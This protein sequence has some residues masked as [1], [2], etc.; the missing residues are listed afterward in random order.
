MTLKTTTNVSDCKLLRFKKFADF[1]GG[2]LVMPPLSTGV[3]ENS[4]SPVTIHTQNSND[5]LPQT[6][7]VMVR[8]KSAERPVPRAPEEPVWDP[9][10]APTRL[11]RRAGSSD[12]SWARARRKYRRRLSL[13]GQRLAKYQRRF[14]LAMEIYNRKVALREQAISLNSDKTPGY[15]KLLLWPEKP[16]SGY[17]SIDSGWHYNAYDHKIFVIQNPDKRLLNFR[18]HLSGVSPNQ[19]TL[20]ESHPVLPRM[21][22][23]AKLIVHAKKQARRKFYEHLTDADANVYQMVRERA[24][25]YNL[26][27]ESFSALAKFLKGPRKTVTDFIKQSGV[28]KRVANVH[29]AYAFGVAPLADDLVDCVNKFTA[30]LEN[31]AGT[32]TF[33]ISGKGYASEELRWQEEGSYY[34][35]YYTVETTVTVRYQAKYRILD[36][37]RKELSNFGLSAVSAWE[38]LPWSFVFDWALPVGDFLK[39]IE[40][41][42]N[43]SVSFQNG[44]ETIRTVMKRSVVRQYFQTPALTSTRQERSGGISKVLVEQWR[45]RRLLTQPPVI[46]VPELK[47]PFSGRHIALSLSLWRQRQKG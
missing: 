14:N 27:R 42:Q 20:G 29:L 32:D 23:I 33:S 10:R 18:H 41:L 47:N 7:L 38:L 43:P 24:Q 45:D 35:D 31:E 44:T 2:T 22:D 25:S 37:V 17:K 15:R 26:L 21:T 6:V 36:F 40:T 46:Q 30:S 13:Y 39:A 16:Y 4:L 8:G 34:T 5:L 3:T 19:Q 11:E 9:P 28:T 1:I 12:A